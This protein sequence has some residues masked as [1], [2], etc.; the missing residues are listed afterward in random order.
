ML[1]EFG[2]DEQNESISPAGKTEWPCSP[3]SSNCSRDR[4][5]PS[6]LH[7]DAVEALTSGVAWHSATS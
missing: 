1:S 5:T 4:P 7:P 3:L 2:L 6:Q